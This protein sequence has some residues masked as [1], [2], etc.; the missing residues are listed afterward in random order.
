MSNQIYSA[1]Y[2]GVDVYEFIHSTGSIMKR[3]KD[4]W[5]NA[6]HILKAANFAKAK[7]T[8]ILEKEVLKETHEKVQG[9]FGKYQGTWVP[10]NIAKR[11]AEKF[12]VYDQLKPLFDFTQT[13][14]SASP[15]PAPKHHHASKMDRKKAIRSAS[16]SAI[17]ETKRSSKKSEE[18]Q[19]QN[20][21]L[22]G[23][24]TP[25]PRKRGRPVG[26]TRGS[27][28]KLGV[29]LQRSQS[30]MGFPRPAIPNS[31]ISTTQ[32]PSIRSTMGPQ[33]PTLSIME[34]GKP[35]SRQQQ[36]QNNSAQFKEIDLEDGLS[37]D[38]EPPQQLQQGFN[39]GT[40]FVPQQQSSLIQT[41][42]VESIATSASSSPSL[43]TSP[44][45]FADSN[46]F[47]ER[48]PGGGTSPIISM[49]PR[50]SVTSR[51]Q[52]SDI[53]D[54]VN[55]YLSKLVDYFISNEMKSNKSLPQAL[56]HPPPHSA[57]YIDAPIDPELHTAFHWACSMGN[58]PIAK[59]LYE[60]GTSIRSTNSQGQTPLMRS[61]LFH[62]SYTR[63][64]FPRIFQLLHETVFDVDSQSQTVIHHIVKR[65][66][67]TPSAVYYLDVVLSKI[68]DFSPQYRIELLLNAQDK[69]GDTALHIASK[70]GDIVFFNTLVRM[71]ALTTI[72]NKEG[73]TAN[74]IM[75]QQYEQMMTQ[76]GSNIHSNSLNSDLN[77]HVNTH[78]SDVKND[79][80]SMVVMSPISPSE[81][82]TYPSQIATN[83]SRNIP[84][85]VNSMKQMASIYNDLHEQHDEELK[86]LQKTLKSLSKTKI[87]VDLK[88]LEVLKDSSEY[89]NGEAQRDEDYEVLSH[90][91]QQNVENLRRRL[92][93]YKQMIKQK[94][95][96]RQM[97]LLG[98]LMEDESQTS[99]DNIEGN[100]NNALERLQLAQELTKLQF[101]RRKQ[102]D[103]LMKK[104][105]D[106]SKI[107]KYRR[108][109]REGT[110]MNIE[111]VD[112][113]LDVILQTLI[114]NNNKNKGAEPTA[115]ISNTNNH[116]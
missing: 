79:V 71:G 69:N 5:V 62:N 92:I 50:Y 74:E 59:A 30:D 19:F 101:Q 64:T 108:I 21:K 116:A 43:P 35:D 82:I 93:R 88:T 85:V 100:E 42:Q 109:I 38:V 66:S 98:R 115:T 90:L 9:G 104:F 52:T 15:P 23:N 46:P 11:L 60:A 81:Y 44:G 48:F 76:N 54:K 110:E 106:N 89:R 55:K 3:K 20:N 26:S 17:M 112:G 84:N 86:S 83:I 70:N 103:S 22:L 27:K 113:S 45:D 61:S 75:N 111:E 72:S 57:P 80:N 28:R 78:N 58:L 10:L 56:L 99:A 41:Q 39:Q 105:E 65:K 2:S 31:S 12:S 73:L 95:E 13:D 91:Q 1:K 33:S 32:L 77:L 67:A 68:K 6:T 7:R 94:L 36:Q 37:S 24:P 34:E 25:V 51:P 18:N 14:G 8:R 49:I 107:H 63:R 4:D 96:Y 16:T 97:V 102:L 40:N 53:N 87:Q 114:V 29:G 47:E